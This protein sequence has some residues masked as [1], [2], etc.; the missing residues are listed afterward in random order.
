MQN[1]LI[2]IGYSKAGSSWLQ[3]YFRSPESGFKHVFSHTE[4]LY[5]NVVAPHPLS[6]NLSEARESLYKYIDSTD[7]NCVPVISSERLCG[8]WASGGYDTKE[9]AIRLKDIFPDANIL[10]VIR[11]QNS[12]INSIYRQYIRKGGGRNL[13]EFLIPP[14]SGAGRFPLFSFDFLE[15]HKII[16]CYQQ[17]FGKDKVIVLPI[18]LLK[19]EPEEFCNKIK[20]FSGLEP[21]G[22]GEFNMKPRN[23]GISTFLAKYKRFFNPLI[24]KDALNDYS[25]YSS[26]IANSIIMPTLKSIEKTIPDAIKA[27]ESKLLMENIGCLVQQYYA[28]SNRKTETLTNLKLNKYLYSLPK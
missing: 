11:E 10:I 23:E 16:D 25:I 14:E 22:I 13:K 1:Q 18:E 15:Y 6:F 19:N 7:E 2:H 26:N 9:I 8:H 12:M 28:E 21:S 27:K 17:L 3:A 4:L 20:K 5:E 24:C